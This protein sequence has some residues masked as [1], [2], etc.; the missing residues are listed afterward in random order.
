MWSERDG[1]DEIE[2]QTPPDEA[3]RK[4]SDGEIVIDDR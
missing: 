3:E 2:Q 1:A 4:T